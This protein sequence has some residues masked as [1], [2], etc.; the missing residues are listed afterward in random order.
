M[1]FG[2]W[3]L[4]ENSFDLSSLEPVTKT[5][6]IIGLVSKQASGLVHGGQE[7]NGH[8]DVGDIARRQGEGDRSATIIGQS[9]DFA[10]SSAARAPQ[11]LPRTPPFRA[12]GRAVRFDMTGID[13][14][15]FR[16][17]SCR[18][19]LLED[20]L[21][22]A[23]LRPPVVAVI[24]RCMRSILRGAIA[25]AASGLKDMQD[26]TDHPAIVY[27]RL[28]EVC[29]AEDGAQSLPSASSDNHNK[30]VIAA[31]LSVRLLRSRDSPSI[32]RAV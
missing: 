25:P 10:S 7:R 27:A 30:C 2:G 29:R 8:G 16:H 9:M 14:E 31:S 20:L 6:G 18:R 1:G 15:L 19:H 24:D 5:V 13:A 28:A 17:R 26:A 21:P 22:D 3:R 11:S 12:S 23:A 4:M 32:Q